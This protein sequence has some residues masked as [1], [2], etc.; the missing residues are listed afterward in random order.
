[1]SQEQSP[2]W[3]QAATDIQSIRLWRD[4]RGRL[5]FRAAAE[6]EPV[7]GVQLARCFPWSLP[8]R[9]ISIRDSNGGELCLLRSVEQAEPE[10]RR[11]ME[12]ELAAQEFVPRITAVHGVDDDF[13]VMAWRVQT[14]R[15]PIELQVKNVDDIRQLDERRVVIKDHA[16]GL[17]EVPDITLLDSRSRRLIE[18]HLA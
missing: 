9:Y 5:V 18:D 10:T 17:F 11:I 13:D 6:A 4:E 7:V 3:T 12:E 1:M 15:G 14:D 16:G 2:L 8:D